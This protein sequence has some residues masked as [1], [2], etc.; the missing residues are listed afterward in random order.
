MSEIEELLRFPEVKSAV[1]CDFSGAYHDAFQ[2][3]DGEAIAGIVGFVAL[4][5]IQL[6][7]HLGLG[8]L[9]SIAIATPSRGR[10]IVRRGDLVLTGCVEPA[11]ALPTVVRALE[12]GE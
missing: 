5:V 4:T 11:R 9:L 10:V 1:V 2:E 6:G 12:G 3:T 8:E 7:E